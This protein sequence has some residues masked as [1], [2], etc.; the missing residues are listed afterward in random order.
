MLVSIASSVY[1][2]GLLSPGM[3]NRTNRTHVEDM[4]DPD[5]VLFPCRNLFLIALREDESG[6]RI[7]FTLLD[8]LPLDPCQGSAIGK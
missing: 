5:K 4:K 6:H 1:K 8:D 7:S 2:G 3:P